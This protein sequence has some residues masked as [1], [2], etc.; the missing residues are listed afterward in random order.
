MAGGGGGA[1][2]L[3]ESLAADLDDTRQFFATL[4]IDALAEHADLAV[5]RDRVDV[6]IFETPYRKF[7]RRVHSTA[8]AST[9]KIGVSE[10]AAAAGSAAE[11][12]VR[13]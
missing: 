12:G 2:S 9:Q 4:G 13:D 5:Q 3:E 11:A 1:I 10:A 8:V 7:S 6:D